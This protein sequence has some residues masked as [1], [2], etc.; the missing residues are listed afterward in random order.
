MEDDALW[1]YKLIRRIYLRWYHATIQDDIELPPLTQSKARPANPGGGK[2]KRRAKPPT[3][4][5]AT[6][7]REPW[8]LR[9]HWW[10]RWLE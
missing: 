1:L 7:K 10:L 4:S 9:W 5:Q 6:G 3:K 2:R 8:W